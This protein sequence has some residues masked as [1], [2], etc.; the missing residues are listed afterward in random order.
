MTT[1]DGGPTPYDTG[2]DYFHEPSEFE[3]EVDSFKEAL[4]KAVKQEIT[5]ELNG[6]RA[7]VKEQ[8]EKLTNLTALES[9][10]EQKRIEYEQKLERTERFAVDKVRKEGIR[11]LLDV[12]A[13]PRY[14][15][16]TERRP[17]PKCSKCNE[18]RKLKYT[19]PRGR[20]AYEP[21]ECA[22][23]TLVWVV[24]EQLVHEVT[25]R[26]GE[27]IVWYDSTARY[28]NRDNPDS[29]GGGTVL[30]S[31]AGVSIKEL[32]DEPREY[33]F[34]SKEDAL[35]VASSLNKEGGDK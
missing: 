1:Y 22:A 17:Q 6:L 35:I 28:Y 12:L 21:C 5:D 30:K 26:F 19:T 8:G 27:L 34:A 32:M 16:D 15:I 20:I 2:Y 10:A 24:Q 33:G 9:A 29:I 14:R 23:T 31:P 18:D 11:K 25:K 3:Q 4:R 13:E 7:T